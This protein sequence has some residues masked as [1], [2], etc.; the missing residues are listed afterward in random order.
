MTLAR[1]M[2]LAAACAW[3][4]GCGDSSSSAPAGQ[5]SSPRN[6]APV[7]EPPPASPALTLIAAEGEGETQDITFDTIKFE[8]ES[9]EVEFKRSMLTEQIEELM[10]QSVRIRGYILPTTRAKIKRFVLVRDNQE[11]CFGP[12]AWLF[13]C[14]I[15]EMQGDAMATYTT[16]PVT[17]EGV[18]G[19]EELKDPFTKTTRAIYHLDGTA[20]E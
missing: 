7:V 15:V 11:C 19:F 4:T 5:G 14:I 3:M 9:K 20:V 6:S 2:L 18:F 17:V 16:R 13:D 10:G 12:G 1:S 8:M